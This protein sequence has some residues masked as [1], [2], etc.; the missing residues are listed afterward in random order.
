M[1]DCSITDIFQPLDPNGLILKNVVYPDV[2]WNIDGYARSRAIEDIH[3]LFI[4]QGT[5]ARV[6]DEIER[7]LL[8]A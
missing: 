8:K 4:S 2:K 7:V 3:E 6:L 5:T 1:L